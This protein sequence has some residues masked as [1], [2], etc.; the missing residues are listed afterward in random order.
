MVSQELYRNTLKN[1][2]IIIILSG[3]DFGIRDKSGARKEMKTYFSTKVFS[4]RNWSTFESM[5]CIYMW[6]LVNFRGTEHFKSHDYWV[7]YPQDQIM[8]EENA[9]ICGL[10][11]WTALTRNETASFINNVLVAAVNAPCAILRSFVTSP[12]LSLSPRTPPCRD[13]VTFSCAAWPV[14]ISSQR[15]LHS[16]CLS[17][18]DWFF[19]MPGSRVHTSYGFFTPFIISFRLQLV[20]LSWLSYSWV[21]IAIMLCPNHWYI[22][23]RLP[24]K[25]GFCTGNDDL[26]S[27][28]CNKETNK[29]WQWAVFDG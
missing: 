7:S 4:S 29:H 23:Q 19:R 24:K 25:V 14:Q 22:I 13:P 17:C 1:P 11:S 10:P 15:S 2:K 28:P 9:T 12:L 16:Q 26:N 18:G 21:L 20:C 8:K 27:I 5:K 3:I 6:F